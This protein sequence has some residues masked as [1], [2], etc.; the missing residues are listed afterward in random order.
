MPTLGTK[1]YAEVVWPADEVGCCGKEIEKKLGREIGRGQKKACDK[2]LVVFSWKGKLARP[3][4]LVIL[5]LEPEVS[6][7]HQEHLEAF[8]PQPW[9][10]RG[11]NPQESP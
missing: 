3:E 9:V 4:T 7:L 11:Q 10:G 6:F 1:G 5:V 2:A 8:R